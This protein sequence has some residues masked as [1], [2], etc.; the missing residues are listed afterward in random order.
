MRMEGQEDLLILS[1]ILLKQQRKLFRCQEMILMEEQLELITLALKNQITEE[2]TEVEEED[3]EAAMAAAAT[4]AAAMAVVVTE[5][6]ATVVAAMEAVA[7]AAEEDP[8]ED[9]EEEAEAAIEAAEVVAMNK[10]TPML[11]E[12]CSMTNKV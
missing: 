10:A 4:E 11:S 6:V 2:D 7:M 12:S 3:L 1:S 8:E 5:V 9:Q